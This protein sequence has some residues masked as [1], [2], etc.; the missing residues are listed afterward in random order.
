MGCG[1]VAMV[2]HTQVLPCSLET[3]KKRDPSLARTSV[4]RDSRH[5]TEN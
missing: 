1:V 2:E 3:K 5:E 4:T